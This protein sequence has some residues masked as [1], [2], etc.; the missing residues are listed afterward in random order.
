MTPVPWTVREKGSIVASY[1][2][3]SQ[4]AKHTPTLSCKPSCFQFANGTLVLV[5]LG[6]LSA[7][8]KTFSLRKWTL[9]TATRNLVSSVACTFPP[10]ACAEV[11]AQQ[12]T[13]ITRLL[14]VLDDLEQAHEE[15]QRRGQGQL[16]L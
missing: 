11:L 2:R 7:W 6:I 8:G 15:F 4:F 16:A 1:K 10:G 9:V 13:A 14:Q 12:R 3:V 5:N